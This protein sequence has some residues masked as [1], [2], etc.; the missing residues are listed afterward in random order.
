MPRIFIIEDQVLLVMGLAAYLKEEY[1]N[2]ELAGSGQNVEKSLIDI[3]RLKP[4]VVILDLSL[5]R[6]DPILNFRILVTAC[7][8]IPVIIF[9]GESRLLWKYR[10]MLEGAKAYLVKEL[11]THLLASAIMDVI[12][13]RTL[14]PPDLK[15]NLST[16]LNDNN[17]CNLSKE[18]LEL[19]SD[20]SLGF[21]VK[22]MAERTGKTDSTITKTLQ[23]L[24]HRFAAKTNPELVR[25]FFEK[26]QPKADCL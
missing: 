15:E 26:R 25:V 19:I 8:L 21:Q 20:L 11:E 22:E 7:P 2:I 16:T 18:E 9:T 1:P 24:R 6:T 12:A 14:I 17:P 23:R 10:M 5:G 4:D 3:G 13:G